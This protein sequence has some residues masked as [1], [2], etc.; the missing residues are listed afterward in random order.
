MPV[1]KFLDKAQEIQ[2]ELQVKK[3]KRKLKEPDESNW[4][5]SYADLM[6][7]LF[8]FFVMMF[9]MAKLNAPEYEKIAEGMAVYFGGDFES[10]SEQLAKFVTMVVQEKGLPQD[11]AVVKRD[12][13]GVQVI[14]NSEL[15]F[16]PLSSELSPQ[17]KETVQGLIFAVKRRQEAENKNYKIVVEGHTDNLPVTSGIYASNWELSA[18]RAA[19][20]VRMFLDTGFK[21]D[22]VVPIGYADT[23]PAFPA[24]TPAGTLDRDAMAKNRR[25]VVR[26]LEPNMDSIPWE[27][28]SAPVD[29]GAEG[30]AETGAAPAGDSAGA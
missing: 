10:K 23:R 8:T 15:F 4:L 26:I 11:G 14:F 22:R 5:V 29:A 1:K 19:K 25:V 13:T 21:P 9:S 20:V 16:E 27:E 2:D 24:R 7:L 3:E 18:A 28:E 12:Y 17:G 6:T 30:S